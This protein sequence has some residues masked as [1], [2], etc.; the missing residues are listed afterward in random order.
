MTI[1]D[2]SF[3]TVWPFT[4]LTVWACVLLL[5]DLL[6]PKER[7]AITALLAALGLAFTLSLTLMQIGQKETTGFSGMVV[8]DGFSLF[9]N[10]LLL[11]SGLLGVALAYGYVRRM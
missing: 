10:S 1:A 4:F 9:V 3:S 8:M 11:I 2:L 7:K 6:L 5:V